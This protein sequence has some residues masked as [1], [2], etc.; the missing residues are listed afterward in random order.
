[1]APPRMVILFITGQSRYAET[2]AFTDP[3]ETY[4]VAGSI[5]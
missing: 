1:M 4:Q 3:C 2:T 5:H